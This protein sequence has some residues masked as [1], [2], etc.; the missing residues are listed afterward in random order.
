M[1]FA[2]P[3]IYI[4][5]GDPPVTPTLASLASPGPLTTQPITATS[6]DSLIS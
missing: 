1:L 2:L 4:K 5:F 6:I 3:L